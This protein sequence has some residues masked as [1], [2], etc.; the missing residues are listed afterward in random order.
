[1]SVQ[2]LIYL[3][4]IELFKSGKKSDTQIDFVIHRATQLMWISN[5]YRN[6]NNRNNNAKD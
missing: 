1:M 6:N 2:N 5:I 4:V 3:I